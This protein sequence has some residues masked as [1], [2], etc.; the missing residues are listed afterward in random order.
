[1]KEPLASKLC[2][3]IKKVRRKDPV[4]T[5]K[6]KAQRAIAICIKSVLHTRGK[7]IKRFRCKEGPKLKLQD[8]PIEL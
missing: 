4:G 5:R 7:T 1:M 6:A 2:S 8:W 3:C